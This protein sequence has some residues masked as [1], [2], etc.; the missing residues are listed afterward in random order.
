MYTKEECSTCRGGGEEG[1]PVYGPHLFH[2]CRFSRGR[3]NGIEVT[4]VV[5]NFDRQGERHGVYGYT[6]Q[7]RAVSFEI[8]STPQVECANHRSQQETNRANLEDE[9]SPL[10][11][12]YG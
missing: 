1:G 3:L 11:H 7:V 8:H 10:I 4:S 6:V 2:R 5:V 12:K 9:A